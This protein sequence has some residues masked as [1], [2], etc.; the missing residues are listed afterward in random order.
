M[1]AKTDPKVVSV[2]SRVEIFQGLGDLELAQIA[3]R[4]QVGKAK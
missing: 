3:Q 2:L 4:C 1:D